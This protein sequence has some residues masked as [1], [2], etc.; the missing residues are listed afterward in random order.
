M[1]SFTLSSLTLRA[2]ANVAFTMETTR[3]PPSRPSRKLESATRHRRT[4]IVWRNK[5]E[6]ALYALVRLG[7]K[8]RLS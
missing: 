1:Q 6:T 3:E 2:N 8:I 7:M 4:M 5:N